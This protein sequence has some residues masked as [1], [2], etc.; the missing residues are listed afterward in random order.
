MPDTHAYQ[1]VT[2]NPSHFPLATDAAFKQQLHVPA[3]SA[4]V[5]GGCHRSAIYPHTLQVLLNTFACASP[6]PFMALLKMR[7][8]DLTSNILQLPW[9]EA[10][11]NKPAS[12]FIRA[13]QKWTL[14]FFIVNAA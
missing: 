4:N 10:G 11:N 13:G 8:C 14:I 2:V 1:C 3:S 9:V 6:W 5:N 12:F 7:A